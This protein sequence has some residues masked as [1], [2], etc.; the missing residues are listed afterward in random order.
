M[1]S[2]LIAILL[3]CC[4]AS[5]GFSQENLNLD[6]SIQIALEKSP[7]VLKTKAE[8]KAAEAVAGQAV[9]GFLP[10]LS[11]SAG[12]GKYYA[13]PM[14]VEITMMGSPTV[15]AYGTDEQADMSR[16]SASL[17]QALF[18]GGKLM[19]SVSMA[20]KGLDI[21]RQELRRIT[22]EVKYNVIS[23]YYGVLKA[24]GLV[25]LSDQSV[26]MAK[27]HLAR[28]N[29][30]VKAG[31]STRADVLRGEVQV[32]QAEIALTRA[33]QG[34]DIAQNSFNN[35][36]GRDL[37]T[38][39]TLRKIEYDPAKIEAY[40]Y[41]QVLTIAYANRPD[42]LQYIL[43]KKISQDEVGVAYSGL[44]PMLSLVGSYDVNSTKYPSFQ[45]DSTSWTAMLSGA[46]N[47]FDGTATWHKINE[48][49]A[50]V[51]AGQADETNVKRAI[52]LEVK[53]ANFAIKSSLEG[54]EA[55][56]KAKE[57]AEENHNIAELRYNSGVGTNLEVID[58]QVALTQAGI[59]QLT[60]QY[61]LLL[62]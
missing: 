29:A 35:T 42:W 19:S 52:A 7:V 3:V 8:I 1:K 11:L 62:A 17:S 40:S 15:F 39:V 25:E 12:V 18:T 31:M 2:V 27:N 26:K 49:K 13:E 37:E 16:Y 20:N 34:L 38:T 30:L 41:K 9:A 44:W 36:I 10:Q 59:D 58:A 54:L 5:V 60:A 28:I 14:N 43:T 50:K 33:K 55:A 46:W 56:N 21:A 51:E 48:A 47:I 53:D 24:Q 57:L 61:D 23:A 4:V 6:Q 22:Q 45:S 32:A